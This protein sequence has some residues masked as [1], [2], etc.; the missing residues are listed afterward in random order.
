MIY[1]SQIST[2]QKHKYYLDGYISDFSDP[3][4]KCVLF[5]KQKVTFKLHKEIG[6]AAQHG[7]SCSKYILNFSS[8]QVLKWHSNVPNK[9]LTKTRS[10]FY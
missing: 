2:K 8:V 4:A 7:L 9:H 10:S 6:S 5:N 1:N 3:N